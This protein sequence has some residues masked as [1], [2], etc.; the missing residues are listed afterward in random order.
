MLFIF[1][2]V[3]IEAKNIYNKFQHTC[4]NN[5]F[6]YILHSIALNFIH[7]CSIFLLEYIVNFTSVQSYIEISITAQPS[8]YTCRSSAVTYA[9]GTYAQSLRSLYHPK[10]QFQTKNR[11]YCIDENFIES[12]NHIN[13]HSFLRI[14]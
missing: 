13:E 10:K 9:H 4:A 6:I 5:T 1:W 11:S 2:Y 14:I 12:K 8:M 3:F 7:E